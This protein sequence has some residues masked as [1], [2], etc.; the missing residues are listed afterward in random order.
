MKIMKKSYLKIGA[1]LVGVCVCA[2]ICAG[3]IFPG[4]ADYKNET[5]VGSWQSMDKYEIGAG[6]TY[7][8]IIEFKE[9]GVCIETDT[10]NDGSKSN[11]IG[12]WE[13]TGDGE[14]RYELGHMYKISEDGTT[15]TDSYGYTL[16]RSKLA[17]KWTE[18]DKSR[19][20]YLEYVLDKDGK[21]TRTLYRTGG[22]IAESLPLSWTK[23]EDTVYKVYYADPWYTKLEFIEAGTLHDID[24]DQYLKRV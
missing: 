13:Q 5:L 19:G 2:L 12:T 16:S 20:T 8:Y 18:D 22:E 23:I 3:C 17:G 15:L 6:A 7:Q 4:T 11:W 24:H 14:Y 1:L 21:G 10:W 9:N